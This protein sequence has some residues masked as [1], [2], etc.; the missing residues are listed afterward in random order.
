MFTII[1][2]VLAG[3]QE[4]HDPHNVNVSLLNLPAMII[5]VHGCLQWINL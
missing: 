5:N 3:M 2:G 1:I 4:R